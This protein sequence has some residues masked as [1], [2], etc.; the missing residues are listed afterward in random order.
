M[1]DIII[2][3]I[4]NLIDSKILINEPLKKHTTFGV[5]GN[6]SI[7]IYPKDK[8][9]LIKILKFT[10]INKIK[11]FFM[12]SGSNLLVHDNGFDGVIISL[13]NS[14]K[15]FEVN[16]KLEV[17]I[18][19]GVML[20]NMVRTLT[21]KSVIG[22]ESLVGVP[23]TL[24]GALIMNAG[25]YGSEISNYLVSVLSIDVF[26]NEKIYN[27][28]DINFSYRYSS[29]P[30][31]EI[32]I[33]AK[34]QFKKGDLEKINENQMSASTKRKTNQP[35]RYRSAGSVFKNPN[36]GPAAGYLID[37]CNLKGLRIGDAEISTKHANFI[38]NYGNASAID[39]YK[40][41]RIIKQKVKAKFN[42][43]LELEV[44][45]LGFSNEEL[46]EIN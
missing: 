20:G 14:F 3:K 16:E 25:A 4:T 41:I 7:F 38:I 23:G 40:L 32:L 42:T 11:I 26:G 13:K 22:L 45:L 17:N 24:G 9:D 10:S 29:F 1:N 39:I 28:D 2:K 37:Q 43:N 18:G 19:T 35:L 31:S 46:K 30:K 33:E 21:K 15:N 8:N 27:K 6:S 36:D 34:F 44:K 5:G 12:G